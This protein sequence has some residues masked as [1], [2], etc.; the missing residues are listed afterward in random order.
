M[1]LFRAAD[2]IEKAGIKVERLEYDRSKAGKIVYS[3]DPAK[4]EWTMYTEGWGAGATRAWWDVS[5]SQMYAPWY[6]YMAGGATEGFWNYTNDEMDQLSQASIN[7]QFL[8]EKEYWDMNLKAMDIGIKEAVRIWVCT[9]NQ[10]YVAN[11]ARVVNRFAY[12][13]GDGLNEWSYITADVKAEK[14][15]TK[16]LRATQFSARGSLFMSTW[17]P[18][19]T[20]GFTDTYSRAIADC[21]RMFGSFEAPNSALDTQYLYTWDPKSVKTQV[22]KKG[23]ELVGQIPVPAT[24]LKY[25]SKSKTWKEVGAGTTAFSTGTYKMQPKITWHNGRAISAMDVM[26]AKIGRAHV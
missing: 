19:G 21:V 14:D 8:N 5:I 25:D 4:L 7:G 1:V 6:G 16:V 9:Q 13:L 3:G 18:I 22:A 2:Q 10:Y 15:G 23:D 26:Y 24:A 12:G 17:D 11:K 20:D